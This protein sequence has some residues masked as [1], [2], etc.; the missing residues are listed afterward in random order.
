MDFLNANTPPGLKMLIDP[1]IIEDVI[2]NI[3]SVDN[4]MTLSVSVI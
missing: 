1:I 4:K 2:G 3:T